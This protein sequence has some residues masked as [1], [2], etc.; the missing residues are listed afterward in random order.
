M[1][2]FSFGRKIDPAKEYSLEEIPVFASLTPSEQ[3]LIEKKAR[4][5]EYK[6]GD[7]VYAEGTPGEAFYVVVSGR[8]RLFTKSRP[9]KS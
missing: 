2:L 1:A 8:F 5:V 3:R 9:G 7:I 4:I 6:R